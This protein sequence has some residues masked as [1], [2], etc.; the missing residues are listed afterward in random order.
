MEEAYAQAL[1][2]I[3]EKGKDP[4]GAV[5]ALH[6]SLV[7]NGREGLM[8]RIARMFARLAARKEQVDSVVLTVAHEG[9]VRRAERE[10]GDAIRAVGVE[11]SRV[12]VKTDGLLIGGWRLEGRET[13]VDASFRKQL[14][15]LYNRATKS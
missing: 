15:A 7:M 3:V 11:L 5:R 8:P 1:W 14:L 6:A 4:R 9:D 12:A 2:E 13:L 10:A